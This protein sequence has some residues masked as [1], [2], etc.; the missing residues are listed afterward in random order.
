MTS[1]VPGSKEIQKSWVEK[2]QQNLTQK[3]G[4]LYCPFFMV[5]FGDE[6]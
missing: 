1:Q 3:Q 6:K 4:L 2:T 5:G